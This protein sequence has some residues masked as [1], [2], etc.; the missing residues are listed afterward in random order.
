MSGSRHSINDGIFA[1]STAG[2]SSSPERLPSGPG[3]PFFT[4][5]D[6]R[7]VQYSMSNKTQ[8]GSPARVATPANQKNVFGLFIAMQLTRALL[9]P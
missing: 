9:F 3:N 5:A 2:T 7:P 6:R 1:R 4:R 8:T